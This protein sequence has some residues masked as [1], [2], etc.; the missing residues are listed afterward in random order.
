VR[1]FRTLLFFCK[2]YS[3]SLAFVLVALAVWEILVWTLDVA[4]YILPPPSSVLTRLLASRH[5]L[6]LHASVTLQE[7]LGGFLLG[8][9]AGTFFALA[10]ARS[11]LIERMLYPLI[12]SSQTFPKEALAPVFVV[13]FG[14]GL[15]PKVVIAGLISFFPVVV[16]TT[17]GLLSVDPLT[18]DLLHVLSASQRQIF[19]K[20][21][22]PNAVPYLF[23]ALK[24]CITLSVIGAVVG[25]FVG[26]S[27]GLGH[28]IRLANS[29]MAT[30]L[31]FAALFTLGAMGT[32]L[33]LCVE[34]LEKTALK[35]WGGPSDL[36]G[37]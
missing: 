3:L 20:V 9:G 27:A 21:R 11:P 8:A 24:M 15:F 5:L 37:R 14:F 33:F 12:I 7:A 22:L 34:G 18:L 19:F 17:R 28:L 13:W 2:E 10:M 1:R 30:D 36:P 31:I 25:E 23:A 29:E 26:A 6:L 16:N 4:D 32:L 35:R